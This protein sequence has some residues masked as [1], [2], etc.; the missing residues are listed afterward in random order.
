MTSVTGNRYANVTEVVATETST[1]VTGLN[2]DTDYEFVVA[3]VRPGEGGEGW[4]SP[5]SQVTT[6]CDGKF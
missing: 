1:E 4:P 6:A 5:V 2:W 3:A